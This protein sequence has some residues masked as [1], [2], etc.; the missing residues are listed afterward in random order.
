MVLRK[1]LIASWNSLDGFLNELNM[2]TFG[3]RKEILEMDVFALALACFVFG[4]MCLILARTYINC[5]KI[6]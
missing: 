2:N 5:G 6:I 1:E 3:L 4:I